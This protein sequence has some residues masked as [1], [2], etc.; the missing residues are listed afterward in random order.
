MA[1]VSV[2]WLAAWFAFPSHLPPQWGEFPPIFPA[3]PKMFS[4]PVF[5]IIALAGLVI[6]VFLLKPEWFGFERVSTPARAPVAALPWWFW[7]GGAVMGFF[8]FLMIARVPALRPLEFY[9]FSPLWYG[10]ILVL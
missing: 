3:K 5:I 1:L 2:P 10:F 8:L 9:A 6:L 7:V 4:L